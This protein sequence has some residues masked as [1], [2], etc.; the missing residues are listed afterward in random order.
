MLLDPEGADSLVIPGGNNLSIPGGVPSGTPG[1]LPRVACF[2]RTAFSIS[3]GTGSGPG[4]LSL[5][6]FPGEKG[7][8]GLR[9]GQGHN[10]NSPVHLDG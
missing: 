7:Q 4:F 10:R 6:V 8:P 1:V 5:F 9:L 3:S 2:F